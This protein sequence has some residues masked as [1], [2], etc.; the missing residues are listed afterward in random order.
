M[1]L[2]DRI[3]FL[4]DG[5]RMAVD[6]LTA[7]R[8]RAF[9]TISGV[10]VGVFVVVIMAAAVHGVNESVRQDVESLGP[11]TFAV[12]RRGISLGC[13]G[14]DEKCPDRKNPPILLSEARAIR[15]LR[16]VAAVTALAVGSVGMKF[17]DRALENVG[18][19]AYSPQW[20]ET[21]AGDIQPGR[22]FTAAE[23]AGGA[24]VL[25]INDSLANALFHGEAAVG[26]QVIVAG[27]PFTVIGVYEPK[28]GFLLQLQGRGNDKPRAIIPLETARRSLGLDIRQIWL[29]VRPREDADGVEVMDEVT[30]ALR[31]RRGL[32]PAARSNFAI[33][34]QDR[35]LETFNQFFGAIFHVGIGLSAVGLLVGGV[36]VVAI[37]MISVT[38]RTRE[39]GVRKALGATKGLIL[40]Q[41]L[42]EA[43]TVTTIG[44]SAGLILGMLLAA[45]VKA[46]T[47][48]PASVPASGIASALI[49][50]ALTGIVFG[51]VPAIRAARLDPVEALRYE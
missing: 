41:F 30:A 17:H 23:E 12:Q 2:A 49:A 50:S 18:Y 44:A 40:W 7:N 19:E 48:V 32:R 16:D 11:Q 38:E 29:R 10:A 47:S 13:D 14:T 28:A 34:T 35:L 27:Q 22:N 31:G 37:M 39:I 8:V 4:L 1:R 24:R 51:I 42:I 5:V 3:A 33:I 36:G 46:T 21:D 43:V 45:L 9:L 20:M 25:L 6:A 26:K 15:E